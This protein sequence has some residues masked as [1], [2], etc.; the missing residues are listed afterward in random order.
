LS[1]TR[2]PL[3][4]NCVE[5]PTGDSEAQSKQDGVDR[6]QHDTAAGER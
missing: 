3:L 5:V 4:D 1:Q 2:Q 6:Q